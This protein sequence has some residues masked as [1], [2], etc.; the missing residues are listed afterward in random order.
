[1]DGIGNAI[2]VDVMYHPPR[3]N[4]SDKKHQEAMKDL[5][6]KRQVF[7]EEKAI[8]AQQASVLETYSS[9]LTA[10]HATAEKLE[11]FMDVFVKQ[12]THF[13]AETRALAEKIEGVEKEIEAEKKAWSVD[14]ESKA[15]AARVTVVVTATEAGAAELSLTY[16]EWSKQ[17]LEVYPL[18]P[19]NAQWSLEHHGRR[20]MTF[21]RLWRIRRRRSRCT[22][23]LRSRSGQGKTGRMCH[24]FSQRLRLSWGVRFPNSPRSTSENCQ[25]TDMAT[26]Q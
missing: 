21:G 4:D 7:E 2:I 14:D 11:E 5:S 22:T 8:L 12:K 17:S 26:C 24:W 10:K 6:R 1:M 13:D 3:L 16:S 23:A 18:T 15:R 20:C 19:P 25:H 9:S